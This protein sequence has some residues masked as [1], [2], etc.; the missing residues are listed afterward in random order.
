MSN[1]VREML[2]PGALFTLG[3]DRSGE[4]ARSRN[5]ALV[6]VILA[7]TMTPTAFAAVVIWE[8]ENGIVPQSTF[9]ES[10]HDISDCLIQCCHHAGE[11]LIFI[12]DF[13][14]LNF[15]VPSVALSTPGH[16]ID[17]C[18]WP[19]LGVACGRIERPGT[20]R[21][22]GFYCAPQTFLLPFKSGF[23]NRIET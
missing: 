9:F 10:I 21:V 15:F 2:Q 1:S 14:D 4:E 6:K 8:E 7:A 18:T 20:C 16:R 19:A 23:Y 3:N 17:A 5:A 22:A 12:F 13:F 11:N